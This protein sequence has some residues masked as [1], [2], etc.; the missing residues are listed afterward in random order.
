MTGIRPVLAWCWS[1]YYFLQFQTKSIHMTVQ[2]IF[3]LGYWEIYP[4]LSVLSL[5]TFTGHQIKNCVGLPTL[6]NGFR[7]VTLN[8]P[9]WVLWCCV[10][11]I[12]ISIYKSPKSAINM[13][14]RCMNILSIFTNTASP[15]PFPF[16][17][18]HNKSFFLDRYSQFLY[19][20]RFRSLIYKLKHVA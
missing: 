8:N 4:N 9:F 11:F 16:N 13:L 3:L 15:H 12:S 1:R 6:P 17:T 2:E 18:V 14:W 10:E 7:C 19:I 20:K 5:N